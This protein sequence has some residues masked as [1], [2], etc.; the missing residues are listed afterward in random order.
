MKIDCFYTI[1]Y[2]QGFIFCKSIDN[3]EVYKVMVDKWAY[4]IEVKSIRSAKI[5]ITK[6]S[7]KY[8]G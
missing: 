5:M 7:K 2:K 6:H 8:G 4:V 1:S 3:V